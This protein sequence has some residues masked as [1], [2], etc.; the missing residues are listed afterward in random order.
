MCIG[1]YFLEIFYPMNNCICSPILLISLG[2]TF[3]Q[4]MPFLLL[5]SQLRVP[6]L[7]ESHMWEDT[8]QASPFKWTHTWDCRN[9]PTIRSDGFI[10]H[11]LCPKKKKDLITSIMDRSC[12][13]VI[14]LMERS[15]L[16]HMSFLTICLWV[17]V[18]GH[19]QY[20]LGSITR[21]LVQ[22]TYQPYGAQGPRT[23]QFLFHFYLSW[24]EIY[25]LQSLTF[26]LDGCLHAFGLWR[27]P[28][29]E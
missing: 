10:A 17:M 18:F 13:S 1:F 15:W 16:L 8:T 28:S 3:K 5:A 4:C 19:G 29:E 12:P 7:S 9:Y 27:T 23:V 14:N 24:H 25:Y 20:N 6:T 21:S 26:M 2:P 11:R 22:K